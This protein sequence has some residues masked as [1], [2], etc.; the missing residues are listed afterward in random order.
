MDKQNIES[1]RRLHTQI[2]QSGD[3]V[4]PAVNALIIHIP[5]LIGEVERLQKENQGLRANSMIQESIISRNGNPANEDKIVRLIMDSTAKDQQIA[6]LKKA[7]EMM[8]ADNKE[9]NPDGMG[10]P[11]Y[12][13]KRAQAPQ[14]Q[15]RETMKPPFGC[16]FD[17]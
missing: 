15:G 9:Y 11:A 3:N 6:T 14:E 12:Y 2:M 8:Y 17:E 1:I 13:I 16:T 10:N 7:L 4:S 5:A